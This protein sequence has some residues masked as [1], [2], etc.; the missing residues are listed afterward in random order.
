MQIVSDV[1]A[2]AVHI[3][4][5]YAVIA[6]FVRS[7]HFRVKAACGIYHTSFLDLRIVNGSRRSSGSGDRRLIFLILRGEF[8]GYRSL[9][10]LSYNF[11]YFMG[12]T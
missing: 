1:Y 9:Y 3:S 11:M 4:E 7:Q 12:N 5:R 6:G 2:A 10:I 8:N